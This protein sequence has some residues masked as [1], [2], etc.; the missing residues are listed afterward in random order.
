VRLVFEGAEQRFGA[1]IP[2]EVVNRLADELRVIDEMGFSGYFL[3]VWDVVRVA[4]ERGIRVG[5]GRG[6]AAGSLVAYCLGIVEVNPL[7]YG[8]L[9]ERF[10]NPG[11]KQM[12]DIDI[13]VDQERR[14]ELF[15]YLTRTYGSDCVAHIS[16]FNVV[17]SRA[18]CRDAARVLG[19]E[20]SVGDRLARALPEREFGHDV[21][22]VEVLAEDNARGA[23]FRSLAK[24][25][26]HAE[27]VGLAQRLEGL[28]RSTSVHASAVV[29]ADRP[30]VEAGIPLARFGQDAPIVSQFDMHGV[31]G[32]GLLKLDLLG[33]RTLTVIERTLDLIE[34]R[35]GRRLDIDAIERDDPK[36]YQMLQRGDSIGVFQLE[37]ER[38]RALMR[39]LAPTCF[40][41]IAALVALY[42]PGPI[43]ANMHNDYADRK[44]GR[45]PV[46]YLHP[47]LKPILADTYGLMIYQESIMRV[48]QR[49]AGY[50]LEE[51]DNLRKAAGKKKREIMV[52]EREKFVAGCEATGYGRELGTQLFDIIEPFADYAFNKSHAYAYGLVAYQTAWL[53]AR[54]PVE[55]MAALLTSV[56]DDKDKV[57]IYLAECRRLGITVMPPDVNASDAEVFAPTADGEITYPLGAIRDMTSALASAIVAERAARGPFTSLPDLQ[58]RLGCV[59]RG[60]R[61]LIALAEAGGFRSLGVSRRDAVA[62]LQGEPTTGTEFTDEEI[63]A[64]ERRRLGL[65]VSVLLAAPWAAELQRRRALS[66]AD[67]AEQIGRL[68]AV[69]GVVVEIKP[70]ITKRGQAMGHLILE[71]ARGCGGQVVVFPSTWARVGSRLATGMPL[72]VRGKVDEG[73]NLLAD[74]I[75]RLPQPETVQLAA[76]S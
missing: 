14:G 73:G 54:Y 68:C 71:D 30:L 55:Y 11:R 47:D 52:A 65:A 3:V 31:E 72:I 5:P 17:G 12:P 36:V 63:A 27:V 70:F 58:A 6:S 15:N 21:P 4:R 66:W 1:P 37:R 75:E 76:A 23:A 7:R 57:A 61:P 19:C 34:R 39:S 2:D 49:F 13:D 67:A 50:S 24:T 8:L 60:K 69:G 26:E 35:E 42:R 38:M 48:A 20:W 40:D 16:T 33:L 64:L 44:N 45:R 51:A 32:L 62:Q 53:K 74:R 29:V 18:A 10:L 28:R 56:R 22:F 43:A 9:F 46:T 41:D 25:A 59:T